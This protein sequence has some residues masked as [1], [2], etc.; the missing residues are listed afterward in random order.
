[1]RVPARLA[2]LPLLCFSSEGAGGFG[3]NVQ[4]TTGWGPPWADA[5]LSRVADFV[6]CHGDYALCYYA[7]CSLRAEAGKWIQNATM[8]A[9]CPCEL[10][11]GL[12]HVMINAILDESLWRSTREQCPMGALSCVFPNSAPVCARINAGSFIPGAHRISTFGLQHVLRHHRWPLALTE[13]AADSYAGCMTAPCRLAAD[14]KVAMCECP[15]FKG[16][17]QVQDGNQCDLEAGM[18]PSGFAFQHAPNLTT[19]AMYSLVPTA[20]CRSVAQICYES[21]LAQLQQVQIEDQLGCP[22]QHA[23]SIHPGHCSEHGYP[24]GLGFDPIFST[25]H[26]SARVP[27]IPPPTELLE[28]CEHRGKRYN[29]AGKRALIIATSHSVLG[30]SSCKTCKKTGV[31]SPEMT[32]PY[33]IFRDAGLNVTVATVQGG[34]VPVD[35]VAKYYT[36]WDIRF[37][38]DATAVMAVKNTRAV[39]LVNFTEFDAIYM[40]GGWGAAWDLG[41]SM[42]LAEG[43]TRAFAAG[44]VLGSVC[45]GALGFINAQK[46]DGSLLVK[47]KK[48]TAISNRQVQQLGIGKITPMHPETELRKR[49]A[50][51]A[52]RSGLLTDIDQSLVV[53]DGNIVTGQNQNSACETAQKML[54]K[55]TGVLQETPLLV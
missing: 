30:N 14:G 19:S 43:I 47:G 51:Y 39:A 6:T 27:H 25:V 42:I 11:S 17:F 22:G 49:G 18:I 44:K 9:D 36:H 40:V 26:I 1:M 3:L 12:Y 38:D 50:L 8:T 15:V 10:H 46:P 28:R 16:P 13:C 48:M 37:W 24:L 33:L 23:A 4:N 34:D 21:T 2:V 52:K 41:N 7:Q 5:I 55:F 45:H 29:L 32:I 53:V 20:E 35:T 31:S 54:D